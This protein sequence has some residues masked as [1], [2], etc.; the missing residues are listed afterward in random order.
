MKEIVASNT[1]DRI[2]VGDID[3]VELDKSSWSVILRN[4]VVVGIHKSK[5]NKDISLS[6]EILRLRGIKW[7]GHVDHKDRNVL[8]SKF[9]NLRPATFEQNNAN[10]TISRNNTTGY[11]GVCFCKARNLYQTN[12]GVSGVKIQIGRFRDP[13]EAAKA[14]DK[15]AKQYHGEFAVLNFPKGVDH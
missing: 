1:G 2:Q 7:D 3:F 10:R 12:I 4:G 9:E 11:K 6:H 8:N 15:A 5:N 13:I 14:Y